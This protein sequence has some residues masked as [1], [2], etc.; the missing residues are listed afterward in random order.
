MQ[1]V[2]PLGQRG[3]R[4]LG[5]ERRRAACP[6]CRSGRSPRRARRARPARASSAAASRRPCRADVVLAAAGRA[7]ARRTRRRTGS[8]GS[9]RPARAARACAPC[10][11]ARRRRAR[12]ARP[13][14]CGTRST[15][16]SPPTTIVMAANPSSVER[17]AVDERVDGF[18]HARDVRADRR[19]PGRAELE[20]DAAA[21]E[22]D[23]GSPGARRAD[24]RSRRRGARRCRGIVA[25]KATTSA[26]WRVAAMRDVRQRDVGAE[27]ARLVA[28]GEQQIGR[29]VEADHVALA[30]GREQQDALRARRSARTAQPRAAA[31]ARAAR[32]PTRGARRRRGSPPSPT[33]RRP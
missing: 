27:Q 17:G 20:R 3:Q 24:S 11:T 8:R 6:R 22:H 5:L 1:H 19:A 26:P 7:A 33:S 16:A 32:S 10:C 15:S 18:D 14:A 31:R 9:A 21:A 30:L 2:D 28:R 13:P 12:A 23:R 25:V 4:G 29:H